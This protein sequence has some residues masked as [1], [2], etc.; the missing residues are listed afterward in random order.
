MKEKTKKPTAEKIV[1]ENKKQTR[2]QFSS[3]EKIKIVLE[4]L[5]GEDIVAWVCLIHGIHQNNYFKWSKELIDVGIRI[6]N[7]ETLREA[8]QYKVSKLRRMNDMLK[9][10]VGE[11]YVENMELKKYNGFVS[12]E[13]LSFKGICG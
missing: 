13:M 6:L 10:E 11:L 7:G 2:L 1:K 5:R 9:R 8:T 3:E 4:E 12:K